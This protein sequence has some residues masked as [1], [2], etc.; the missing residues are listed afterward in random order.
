MW[1][2]T[3]G[4]VLRASLQGV[5]RR[6]AMDPGPANSRRKQADRDLPAKLVEKVPSL[7]PA[8]G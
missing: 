5:C 3:W 6:P 2:L 1:E 4:Q 7:H 8:R